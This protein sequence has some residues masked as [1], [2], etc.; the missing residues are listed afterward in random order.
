MLQRWSA[1]VLTVGL[2]LTTTPLAQAATV[3]FEG[4]IVQGH[5]PQVRSG[6]ATAAAMVAH[7]MNPLT[8]TNG[9]A[10]S[11]TVADRTSTTTTRHSGGVAPVLSHRHHHRAAKPAVTGC[12]FDLAAAR[13]AVAS[14]RARGAQVGFAVVTSTGRTLA[15]VDAH[16]A[17]YGA[18][19]TKSM[20]LVA[21]LHDHID[22]DLDSTAGS[23]L[24]SM[25]EVS[26]NAAADWVYAHLTSPSA[27]VEQVASMA[28]MPGFRL[29]TSDPVYT[30]GQSLVTAHDF[31]RLF[32]VIGEMM[33]ASHRS[34]GMHLLASVQERVG[35]LDAGL[36][37]KVYSKEGWK[38]EDT[39]V[40]G[41][42]YV[43]NQAAQFSC[44]GQTYGI[45]VTV[46]HVA[47]QSA[48]EAVVQRV[49]SSLNEQHRG[50]RVVE[51]GRANRHRGWH[52][53]V[54]RQG[55][56]RRTSRYA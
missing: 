8:M 22:S 35:L 54:P 36:P 46:G 31:A 49:A 5:R 12:G 30:L 45:A 55:R 39:G 26:D 16:Q 52:L 25:I 32:S 21:Y 56:C 18:S 33:P 48:G 4:A 40:L 20:L 24:T 15:S 44:R 2:L 1:A 19:I 37:G 34:F 42:P 23:E 6:Q 10:T 38:P 27:D 41:A 50:D 29:D 11:T 28:G 9:Q 53:L 14:E 51:M 13:N 43:V 47:D 3:W 17:N 7:P